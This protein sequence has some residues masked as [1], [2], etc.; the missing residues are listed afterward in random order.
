MQCP[1]CQHENR[2]GAKF[3]DECGAPMPLPCPSCGT[4]NRPGAKFCNACG[5]P[6]TASPTAS[7]F[8]PSSEQPITRQEKPPPLEPPIPDAERRQLTVM[9]CDLADST[10]LSGQLDPEDLRDVIRAYQSTSAEVIQRYDG[11]IAQHLGDGLMVY[12]GWPR[13]HEDDAQRAVHAGLGILAAMQELNARL[14]QEKGIILAVRIGI[15]TGLVV[16]GEVGQGTR[17]EHLALGETPN[18][19]SR[20]EGLAEPDTVAISAATYQ[21][22]QGYFVCDDPRLNTACGARIGNSPAFRTLAASQRGVWSDHPAQWGGGH[23]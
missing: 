1:Q 11:Y 4:E 6:L 15:H 3:C 9:F 23:W 14:E 16:V 2:E 7:S 10:R 12:F 20:I 17:Q 22:V 13:A 19:A 8:T 18:V 21:L 5:T